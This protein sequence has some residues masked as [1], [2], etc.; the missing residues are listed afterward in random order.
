MKIIL[1]LF[2]G[3]IL[4]LSLLLAENEE[5]DHDNKKS[6]NLTTNA[7]RPANMANPNKPSWQAEP[8]GK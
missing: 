2:L 4:P 5:K 1:C 6:S 8:H 3:L 7:P